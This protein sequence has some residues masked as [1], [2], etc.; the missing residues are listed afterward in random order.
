MEVIWNEFS[1]DGQFESLEGDFLEYFKSELRPILDTASE[2]EI[3]IFKK[4]DFYDCKIT[5]DISIFG[6]L[7]QIN[8]PIATLLKNYIVKTAFEK[9][10]WDENE[11]TCKEASYEYPVEVEAPNC[12]T[13]AIERDIPL[14]SFPHHKFKTADFVCMKN[15]EEVRVENIRNFKEFLL[16]FLKV[17]MNAVSYVLEK[18]PYLNNRKVRCA[19]IDG[20]CYAEEALL[21]NDL[22]CED[23]KNIVVNIPVLMDNLLRGEKTKLWDTFGKGLFEY[24]MDVSSDRIFR[25]FFIQADEKIIFLNGFIKKS[26][27]TPKHELDKAKRIMA[28]IK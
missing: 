12:F 9:P 28:Q 3:R 5:K 13:E 27:K 21:E 2:N 18:Y 22:E 11:H 10:F 14:Y 24:R 8:S 26:Q 17:H 19:V 25:L 20:K 16:A 23:L 4:N 6:L 1:L 7:K 15:N